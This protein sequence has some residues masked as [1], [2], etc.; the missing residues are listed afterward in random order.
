[1]K[2]AR[3]SITSLKVSSSPSLSFII[4]GKLLIDEMKFEQNVYQYSEGEGPYGKYIFWLALFLID[5]FSP[6]N[7]KQ[8][9]STFFRLNGKLSYLEFIKVRK[10]NKKTFELIIESEI[11]IN[12]IYVRYRRRDLVDTSLWSVGRWKRESYDLFASRRFSFLRTFGGLFCVI[13]FIFSLSVN[14]VLCLNIIYLNWNRRFLCYSFIL[15]TFFLSR[16][17]HSVATRETKIN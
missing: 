14:S 3:T 17:S 7:S 5:V 13:H 8:L 4:C 1:M 12:K 2:I 16:F 10:S 6:L 9:R 15:Q 11:G